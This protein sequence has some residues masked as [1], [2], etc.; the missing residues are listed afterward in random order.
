[1][2]CNPLMH[3]YPHLKWSV[4]YVSPIL[5]V[6]HVC[7]KGIGRNR[8]AACRMATSWLVLMESSHDYRIATSGLNFMTI[9]TWLLNCHIW[10]SFYTNLHMIIELPHL[11]LIYAN[12]H[13]IIELPPLFFRN[14]H[15]ILLFHQTLVERCIIFFSQCN[16]PTVPNK[17]NYCLIFIKP[18]PYNV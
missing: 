2:S 13:V 1:M 12:L 11:G 10:A 4:V 9:F 3:T 7:N 5:L 18:N 14:L 17:T 8:F 6:V 16:D 15:L